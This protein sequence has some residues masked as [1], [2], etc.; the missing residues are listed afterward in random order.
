MG[1]DANL[2]LAKSLV[3]GINKLIPVVPLD[4]FLRGFCALTFPQTY[5][6]SYTLVFLQRVNTVVQKAI[7]SGFANQ[8]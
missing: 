5:I 4:V 7:K 1:L 3:A 6:L 8:L 2:G